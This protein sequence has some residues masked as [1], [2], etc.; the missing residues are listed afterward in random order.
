MDQHTSVAASSSAQVAASQQILAAL[1]GLCTAGPL[2]ALASLAAIRGLH[3]KWSTWFLLG[4]P[5]AITINGLYVGLFFGFVA[6]V[7]QAA[8]QPQA[9][10]SLPPA[11]PQPTPTVAPSARTTAPEPRFYEAGTAVGGQSVRLDLASIT[12]AAEADRFE[13]VYFLGAERI[14]ATADCTAGTWI[15]RPDLI[16]HRPQSAAT[17]NMLKRVCQV[18]A[19]RAVEPSAVVTAFVFDPPSNIRAAP[20][21]A[22]LC[23]VSTKQSITVW[24]RE[25]DWIQT[26]YC[27]SIGYIHVDQIRF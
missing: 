10:R 18:R 7:R 24:Q 1:A 4:V 2:G 8:P 3:G 12:Q 23:S 15:T 19:G 6:I 26:N 17:E 14:A 11:E 16:S 13:F 22:I 27:G 25:G 21:G 5:A 9:G 20:N